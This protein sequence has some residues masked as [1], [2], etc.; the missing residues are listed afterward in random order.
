[1][2]ICTKSESFKSFI[3]SKACNIKFIDLCAI[4]WGIKLVHVQ[5]ETDLDSKAYLI[6]SSGKKFFSKVIIINSLATY[7]DKRNAFS[8]LFSFIN[9][10]NFLDKSF[11]FD[12]F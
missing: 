10:N 3:C 4:N 7:S 8:R 6:T 12:A 2:S 1:M 11:S 5:A 9:L